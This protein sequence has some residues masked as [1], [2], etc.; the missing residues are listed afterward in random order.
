MYNA[1]VSIFR[2]EKP[3]VFCSQKGNKIEIDKPSFYTSREYKSF[4]DDAVK[5]K[6]GRAVGILTA[7]EEIYMVYNT[8]NYDM[9]WDYRAE[10]NMKSAVTG[11]LRH[12]HGISQPIYGL[13]L[14]NTMEMMLSGTR[15]KEQNKRGFFFVDSTFNSFVYLTNDRY[16][17]VLMKV[18]CNQPVR[19][20]IDGALQEKINLKPADMKIPVENDG[21]DENGRPV[22]FSYLPDMPRLTRFYTALAVQ[23]QIGM[24]VCFDFQKEVLAEYCGKRVKFKVIDFSVFEQGFSP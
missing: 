19:Q 22:L 5:V 18:L 13:L 24:I 14:G 17:E 3:D 10:N 12:Y 16:G 9:K 1:G 2:D 11:Y 6:N 20:E 4:E 8:E 21:I 15:G 7:K 23:E